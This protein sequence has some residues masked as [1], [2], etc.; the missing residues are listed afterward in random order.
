[1]LCPD[2]IIYYDYKVQLAH[3]ELYIETRPRGNKNEQQAVDSSVQS[4]IPTQEEVVALFHD[5]EV[6]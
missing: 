2:Y 3:D 1:M 6:S 4:D 5:A